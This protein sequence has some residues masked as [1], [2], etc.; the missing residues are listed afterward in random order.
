MSREG[1][2]HGRYA[3][4]ALLAGAVLGGCAATPGQFLREHGIERHVIEGAR[5]SHVVFTRSGETSRGT[6]HV[7]LEGD[8]RPWLRGR[9]P[10]ADPTPAN[11][12]ALRL[13]ARDPADA[14]LVGRPCYFGMQDQASCHQ[15]L[16]TD[17][18]YSPAVVDSM[19]EVARELIEDGGY[20]DAVLIG[21][22]GG[23]V[24]ARL[25]AAEL[26]AVRAVLTVN[27]NLDTSAW[28]AARGYRRLRGSINPADA[29]RLR[30]G[31]LHVQAIGMRDAVVPPAVTRSYQQSQD[32]VVVWEYDAFDHVCCWEQHW[33]AI[34]ERFHAATHPGKSL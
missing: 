2:T 23:G 21:Y 14:V 19:V 13:M 17:G 6:L 8:G 25:M 10:A 9:E 28:T 20:P 7:Y 1:A 22:S 32:D 30:R 27:A 24:L 26:P 18:R 3:L 31:L 4:P 12:L 15:E 29:P 11:P 34:L 33:P 16:W 5:F